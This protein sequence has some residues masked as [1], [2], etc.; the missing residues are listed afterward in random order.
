MPGF[1]MLPPNRSRARFGSDKNEGRQESQG[2]DVLNEL[3]AMVQV[4]FEVETQNEPSA[5]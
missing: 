5:V 4:V 2:P 1:V 3:T